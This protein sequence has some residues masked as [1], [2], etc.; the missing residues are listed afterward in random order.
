MNPI[1]IRV[2]YPPISVRTEDRLDYV[3][4]LQQSQAGQGSEAFSR[5]L[6]QRLDATLDECLS[7]FEEGRSTAPGPD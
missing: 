2:G 3:R 6:Y 1:L 4:S 7:A 5:L